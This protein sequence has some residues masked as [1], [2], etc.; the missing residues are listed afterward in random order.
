LPRESRHR[1]APPPVSIIILLC[2]AVKRKPRRI[3]ITRLECYTC[4]RTVQGG[5]KM[6]PPDAQTVFRKIHIPTA[7]FYVLFGIFVLVS[8][9]LLGLSAYIPSVKEFYYNYDLAIKW[10]FGLLIIPICLVFVVGIVFLAF[11][12]IFLNFRRNPL[13]AVTPAL[14]LFI[15]AGVYLL[16]LHTFVFTMEYGSGFYYGVFVWV[17]EIVNLLCAPG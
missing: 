10:I 9:L 3:E 11:V 4:E 17:F 1:R 8:D 7:K 5:F 6:T 13:Y 15:T 16:Y 14:I 12:F 2:H